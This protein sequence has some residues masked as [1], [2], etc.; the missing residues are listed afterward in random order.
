MSDSKLPSVGSLKSAMV[1][2]LGLNGGQG[3]NS[4][5]LEWVSQEL[6]LDPKTLAVMRSGNR[7]EVAYRLAWAR[8]Q[9]RKEGLILRSGPSKWSLR[10]K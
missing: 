4:E 6:E 3:S 7:T 8:T 5:I 2:V 9:A 10:T 1:K